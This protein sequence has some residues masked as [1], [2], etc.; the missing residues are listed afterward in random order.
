MWERNEDPGVITQAWGPDRPL[1]K[2]WLHCSGTQLLGYQLL[3]DL[4]KPEFPYQ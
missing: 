2:S 3:G 1:V 4:S